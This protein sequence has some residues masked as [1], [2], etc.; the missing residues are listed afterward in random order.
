M[1]TSDD[2]LT[3]DAFLGG[4]LHLRQPCEGYRAGIDPVLLAAA[5]EARAGQSV[6]DLG[7]GAGTALLCLGARIAGLELTGLE[8]QPRYADL[9][10]RNAAENGIPARIV[11]G[12]A[13]RMPAELKARAFDRVIANPPYFDRSRG[14]RARDPE[15]EM[16]LGGAL[17]LDGWVEAGARRL[18]PKGRMTVIQRAD[19]LPELMGAMAARLGSLRLRPVAPRAGRDA[20]L[21][22]LEGVKGGRGPARLEAPLILHGPGAHAGD[23]DDYA[24]E[25]RA[26][27]RRGEPLA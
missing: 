2:D 25:A 12:D 17:D 15:R 3:R 18:A 20:I 21:V 19:R 6:L 4:R 24:E 26:I 23:G 27:L 7:T 8:V 10:R 1:S 9:A 5:V 13:G 16:A 11:T 22:L 14:T